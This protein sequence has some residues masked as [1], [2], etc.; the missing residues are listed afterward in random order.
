MVAGAGILTP[1]VG[2]DTGGGPMMEGNEDSELTVTGA[3]AVVGVVANVA[4]V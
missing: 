1:P 4:V 2:G 3:L